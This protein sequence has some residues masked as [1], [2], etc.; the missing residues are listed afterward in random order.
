M[1]TTRTTPTEALAAVAERYG[2]EQTEVKLLEGTIG[3]QH[4][5]QEAHEQYSEESNG[6]VFSSVPSQVWLDDTT[7]E[8]GLDRPANPDER[9]A[10]SSHGLMDGVVRGQG[11]VTT[12]LYSYTEADVGLTQAAYERVRSA[13]GVPVAERAAAEAI[14]VD[15]LPAELPLRSLPSNVRESLDRYYELQ[16]RFRSGVDQA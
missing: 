8:P 5:Q 12:D 7:P 4:R 9:T 3:L 11:R 6:A 2:Y 16:E 13:S 1:S 15:D 10:R 14:I